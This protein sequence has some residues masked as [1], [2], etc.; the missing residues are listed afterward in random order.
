MIFFF[1]SGEISY[2]LVRILPRFKVK[3]LDNPGDQ[4]AAACSIWLRLQL[5]TFKVCFVS[6]RL[7]EQHSGKERKTETKR[8]EEERVVGGGPGRVL[9]VPDCST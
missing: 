9:K 1:Y 6:A 3:T 7:R 5:R 4:G 2:F 8:E